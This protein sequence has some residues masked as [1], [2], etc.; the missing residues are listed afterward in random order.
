MPQAVSSLPSMAK[1][2]GPVTRF[3]LERSS[4]FGFQRRFGLLEV[5][6]GLDDLDLPPFLP[7]PSAGCASTLNSRQG[8][9][10]LERPARPAARQVRDRSS[11][12]SRNGRDASS[13]G[14]ADDA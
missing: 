13:V 14:L 10:P 11:S 3:L 9:G 12:S 7:S 4:K 5:G 1:A 2:T 8:A 6:G